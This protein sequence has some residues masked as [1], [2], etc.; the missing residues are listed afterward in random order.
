MKTIF[1]S[2]LFHFD[3]ADLSTSSSPRTRPSTLLT[4]SSASNGQFYG[5]H[6]PHK[7]QSFN[8]NLTLMSMMQ[9]P[10]LHH[11]S[12]PYKTELLSNE[13]RLDLS[14]FIDTNPNTLF[15]SSSEL[16]TPSSA[17][18]VSNVYQPS[19]IVALLEPSSSSDGS[20]NYKSMDNT[21]ND[22]T[23]SLPTTSNQVPPSC[24]SAA[25]FQENLLSSLFNSFEPFNKF[26]P[27][28]DQ[29]S[30][31]RYNHLSPLLTTA[32]STNHSPMSY[33]HNI[34]WR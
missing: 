15:S 27:N 32:P 31:S 24:S 28:D 5:N 1:F 6:S 8:Q 22:I 10:Y 20:T 2:L 3:L 17:A 23:H 4:H 25:L 14:P 9:Q 30:T 12:M 34:S 13:N 19:D 26:F 7:S 21:L 18:S 29:S 33:G 16:N 11:T